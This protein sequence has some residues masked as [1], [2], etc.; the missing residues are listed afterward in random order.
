MHFQQIAY[1]QMFHTQMWQDFQLGGPSR[2]IDL[3]EDGVN[4][5]N[6]CSKE[7]DVSDNNDSNGNEV[8]LYYDE[9][10]DEDGIDDI[11]ISLY[12]VL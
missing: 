8:N 10:T 7:G 1:S 5:E 6:D 12:H 11:A 9:E 4:L 3:N 2:S